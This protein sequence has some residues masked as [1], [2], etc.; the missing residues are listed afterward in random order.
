MSVNLFCI[1]NQELIQQYQIRSIFV[2]LLFSYLYPN[3][4]E[5]LVKI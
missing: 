1:M 3:F 5:K 4:V 2:V